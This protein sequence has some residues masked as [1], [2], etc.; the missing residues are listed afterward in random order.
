MVAVDSSPV[1][2]AR[3]AE[4]ELL[5]AALA[6]AAAGR[7]SVVLLGGEAGIGKTRLLE[8]F[9]ARARDGAGVVIGRCFP[10]SAD[11]APYGSFADLFRDLLR[12]TPPDRLAMILGPARAELG[13]VV[14]ELGSAVDRVNP[15]DGIEVRTASRERLFEL[16]LGIARRLQET[17]PAVIA[18]EDLQWADEATLSLLGYLVRGIREGRLLLVLTV[19]T[20][21]LQTDEA[22]FACVEV[23]GLGARSR[24]DDGAETGYFGIRSTLSF[25]FGGVLTHGASP[26]SIPAGAEFVRNVASR[27]GVA[28]TDGMAAKIV[29]VVG[30]MS[31]AALNVLFMKHFQDVAKGHFIVRR[32]ERKYGEQ[33]IRLAYDR[34]ARLSDQRSKVFSPLEGW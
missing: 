5:D 3:A 33:P 30:A 7:P 6:R 15:D 11:D 10:D 23:F 26:S 1:F 34:I 4:I 9:T 29:P 2:V 18:I 8:E 28:V 24:D 19:R 22:R 32:L 27:F 21:D 14:P 20:E 25:H 16:L 12:Q 31:G 17:R 13:L